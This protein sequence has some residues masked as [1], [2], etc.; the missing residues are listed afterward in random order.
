MDW[1][2]VWASDISDKALKIAKKNA[3]RLLPSGKTIRFL[4]GSLFD[5]LSFKSLDSFAA[6]PKFSLIVSNPPY[7]PCGQIPFLPAEVRNE[8]RIALDG[9]EDGLFIIRQIVEKAPCFLEDG[10]SLAL[11]AAPEQMEQIG[12]LLE[13]RGFSGVQITKD[14][15]GKQR[16][17]KGSFNRQYVN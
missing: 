9:G 1:L 8:P 5:A 14:M 12:R 17:I 4:P 11:E 10:G 13:T 3:D 16:V 6:A 15:S 2:D 7:V